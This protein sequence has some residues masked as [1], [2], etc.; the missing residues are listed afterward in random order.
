[1]KK[2]FV[3]S[4]LFIFTVC[5]F[6]STVAQNSR[7]GQRTAA[8]G[9]QAELN[10][11]INLPPAERVEKLK[12][13]IES[14]TRSNLKSRAE[15]LIVSARAELGAERLQ[16]GDSAAAIEQFR[17]AVTESPASMSDRLFDAIIS[18]IPVN[19]FV[20]GEHGAAFDITKLIEQRVSDNPKRLLVL[21]GFYLN[22]EQ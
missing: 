20:A 17:L 5:F 18:Q 12:A 14:H 16:A 10:D 19:L 11:I 22:T 15:E 8:Q 4:L 6:H 9:D 13:F 3:L 7:A 1:M 2:F 21:A